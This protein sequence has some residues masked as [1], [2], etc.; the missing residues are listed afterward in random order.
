[1]TPA[2]CRA[3][4]GLL[5]WSQGVLAAAA[6]LSRST[7]A[8]FELERRDV[9]GDAV[10]KMRLAL[11]TAGVRFTNGKQHGVKLKKQQERRRRE[12]R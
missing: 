12:R 4:R 5:N 6:A 11:E 1:M 8:D 9:S 3:A 2:Q 7:I 10:S